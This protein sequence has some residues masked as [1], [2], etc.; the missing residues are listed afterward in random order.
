MLT[1][2]AS[3]LGQYIKEAHSGRTYGRNVLRLNAILQ[4]DTMEALR[5][6]NI[7]HEKALADLVSLSMQAR[8]THLH[9]EGLGLVNVANANGF[10]TLFINSSG[11][12]AE[13]VL[14]HTGRPFTTGLVNSSLGFAIAHPDVG[15][16]GAVI[17][18]VHERD[19]EKAI[20]AVLRNPHPSQEELAYALV[21]PA[22][23]MESLRETARDAATTAFREFRS[24]VPDTFP[25]EGTSVTIL[26]VNGAREDEVKA[27]WTTVDATIQPPLDPTLYP[28]GITM[29]GQPHY[30]PSGMVE[31]H[32]DLT[33]LGQPSAV[34][35]GGKTHPEFSKPTLMVKV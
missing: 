23:S 32:F 8:R 12:A 24:I 15:M 26:G 13:R 31:M 2:S 5:L 3:L 34:V 6:G 16:A 27:I 4:S 14:A 20:A 25:K 28:S 17:D 1:E 29:A 35:Y 18:T 30:A 7:P 21:S 9:E 22:V 33:A 10:D 11:A 19:L